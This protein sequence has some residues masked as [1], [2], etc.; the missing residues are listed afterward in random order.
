MKKQYLLHIFILFGCLNLFSQDSNSSQPENSFGIGFQ[1]STFGEGYDYGI[2]LYANSD[3]GEAE[4]LG[5]T[6]QFVY[7][8][9]S[10]LISDFVD[11]AYSF[12]VSL[13]YDVELMPGFEV[14][15]TAGVGYFAV[16]ASD[17]GSTEFY[18]SLGATMSY[19]VSDNIV[20]GLD[21]INPF[22]DGASPSLATS[23]RFQ[24]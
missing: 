10:D 9:P 11:Y 24:I 14:G 21:L 15:P 7:V 8:Q 23:I 19:F 13:K 16:E 4:G 6:A 2:G 5:Y 12:D 18:F 22:L 3:F 20:L 17:A 1:F